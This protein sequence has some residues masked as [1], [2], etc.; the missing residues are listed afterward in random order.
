MATAPSN[1]YLVTYRDGGKGYRECPSQYNFV[2]NSAGNACVCKFGFVEQNGFCVENPN[3]QNQ[4]QN[5][6][7]NQNQNQNLPDGAT[8]AIFRS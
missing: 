2:V 6:I 7:P 1:T 8:A 5:Q 4:N 3:S